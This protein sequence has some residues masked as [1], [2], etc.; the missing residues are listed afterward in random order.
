MSNS[1]IS[2]RSN[3]EFKELGFPII[4]LNPE[5]L[6]NGLAVRVPN[7]L[8]DG[9]MAL[10]ALMM[11]K[12]ILP[13]YCALFV[14]APAS[15]KQM[16][17]M[18]PFVDQVVEL[19]HIHRIWSRKEV[20]KLRSLR[21]GAGILLNHS[22]RD[23]VMVKWAGI[24]ELY[25]ETARFRS[26]MLKRALKFPPRIPGDPDGT[27]QTQR[28]LELVYAMGAPRWQGERPVFIPKV[29]ADELGGEIGALCQHSALL[30]IAPGAAYGEAKRY[31]AVNFRTVARYWI[32]HGGI[33]VILGARSEIDTA[34]SVV[35]GLNADKCYNFCGKTDLQSLIVI[36]QHSK[37]LTGNDS[38]LMHLA[39][40][41]G[42]PGIAIFGPTDWSDTAPVFSGWELLSAKWPC[43]PCLR[44]QCPKVAPGNNSPCLEAVPPSQVIR[45]LRKFVN[46]HTY[47]HKDI[48]TDENE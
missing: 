20:K 15:Q 14:I 5:V 31:P 16:Y 43:G 12:K 48:I 2:Y 35:V 26:W 22:F 25:G 10:P 18:L 46:K 47:H 1:I 21:P 28:Y 38:G 45:R 36:L 8:G 30:A 24:P 37:C 9:V 29:K 17:E 23:T 3:P 40:A 19:E 41:L 13:R 42:C 33:V 7:H 44:R 39:S 4:P 11:I 34:N 32:R 6:R 27:H